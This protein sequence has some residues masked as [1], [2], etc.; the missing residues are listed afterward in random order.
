[1]LGCEKSEKI[2]DYIYKTW[3]LDWK[4]CGVYQNRYDAKVNFTQTDSADYGWFVEQGRDT[5]KFD[6]EIVSDRQINL[7]MVT[8]SIWEGSLTINEFSSGTLVF[9]KENKECAN[10]V[11]HF[12]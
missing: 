10:E 7:L 1:M 8:D 6:V 11:Y 12:E 2:E 5:V 3:D 4:Q 9:E